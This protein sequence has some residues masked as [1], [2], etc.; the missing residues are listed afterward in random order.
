ME[1]RKEAEQKGEEEKQHQEELQRIAV[2][3]KMV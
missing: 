1:A 3:H 2:C